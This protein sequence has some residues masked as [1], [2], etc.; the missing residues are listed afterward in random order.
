MGLQG[1]DDFGRTTTGAS[2]VD[3]LEVITADLRLRTHGAAPAGSVDEYDLAA[4]AELQVGGRLWAQDTGLELGNVC[5][6][7]HAAQP[8]VQHAHMLW[9][10][11]IA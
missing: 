11:P 10:Q 9:F 4:P 8:A 2:R 5:A 7:M 1:A 3:V 6:T